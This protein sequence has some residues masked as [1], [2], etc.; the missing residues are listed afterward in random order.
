MVKINR[1]Q[2]HSGDGPGRGGGLA[3]RSPGSAACL[4][5]VHVDDADQ[6]DDRREPAARVG[7]SQTLHQK[8]HALP[9]RARAELVTST[10][11]GVLRQQGKGGG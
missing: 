5:L 1:F 4:E 2:Q 11:R 7:V 10:D 6:R 3:A 9:A 8:H